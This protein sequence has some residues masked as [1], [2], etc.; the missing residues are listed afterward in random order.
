V[1]GANVDSGERRPAQRCAAVP[2]QGQPDYWDVTYSFRG[3]EHHVQ[4]TFRP[5]PTLTVNDQGEPRL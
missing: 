1:I 4:T 3:M 5:G 2:P